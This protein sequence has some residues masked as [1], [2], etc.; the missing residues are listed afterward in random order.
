MKLIY[1]FLLLIAVVSSN[2]RA[3][4]EHK[5]NLNLDQV[6]VLGI[7]EVEAE[8]DQAILGVSIRVLKPTLL[9]AKQDA[10]EQ[11]RQVLTVIEKAG[12]PKTQYK[13]SSLN[14]YPQYDWSGNK[15]RYKGQEITRTLSITVNDL[16]K[17]SPLLQALVENG[18]SNINNISSGFQDKSALQR[19]ALA[20]AIDDASSK[21]EFIAK[22]LNRDI[23]GVLNVSENNV[24]SPT[25]QKR[26]YQIEEF[27]TNASSRSVAAPQEAFGTQKVT[28]KIN[29]SFKLK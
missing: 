17:L 28:A 13:V 20:K 5:N 14:S 27:A 3:H 1:T 29:A 15:K 21:A 16:D 12:I 2:S 4:Q 7:G 19:Q 18:I 22:K 6:S 25:F 26:S 23:G 10:D 11:Y 9:E 24:Q 8:P